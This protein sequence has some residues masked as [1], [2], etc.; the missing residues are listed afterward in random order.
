MNRTEKDY[1]MPKT[2]LQNLQTKEKKEFATFEAAVKHIEDWY[3]E[4]GNEGVG[5]LVGDPKVQRFVYYYLDNL[6]LGSK[7]YA[8]EIE[9]VTQ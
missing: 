9:I 6:G 7:F 4:G 2:V 3:G 5:R 1:P 8:W